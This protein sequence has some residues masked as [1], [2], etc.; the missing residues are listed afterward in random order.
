MI[1]IK[2]VQTV[3][4]TIGKKLTEAEIQQVLEIYPF[5]QEQDPG[6]TWDLV[7]EQCIYEIICD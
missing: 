1:T 2:D 6:A 5:M 4:E 3:A 7:V